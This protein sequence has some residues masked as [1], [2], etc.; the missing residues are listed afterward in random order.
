MPE[1][2]EEMLRRTLGRT[3]VQFR[4]AP[5]LAEIVLSSHQRV[6]AEIARVIAFE[7][8]EPTFL[9]GVQSL[10]FGPKQLFRYD[11]PAHF[12]GAVDFFI[13]KQTWSFKNLKIDPNSADS[14]DKYAAVAKAMSAALGNDY[15]VIVERTDNFP[16]A[17]KRWEM[18]FLNGHLNRNWFLN[19]RRGSNGDHIHIQPQ[20]NDERIKD[21]I[22]AEFDLT[23]AVSELEHAQSEARE[24]RLAVTLVNERYN[25]AKTELENARRVENEAAIDAKEAAR[26]IRIE[27]EEKEQQ[28]REEARKAEERHSEAARQQDDAQE[29]A[30]SKKRSRDAK[31]LV[32]PPLAREVQDPD[33]QNISFMELIMLILKAIAESTP[34]ILSKQEAEEAYQ[35]AVK[36]LQELIDSVRSA[37]DVEDYQARWVQ[38]DPEYTRQ[39]IEDFL[40][41]LNKPATPDLK[42]DLP[43]CGNGFIHNV[44]LMLG[45]L[46]E[47]DI[48]A[49]IVSSTF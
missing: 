26:R 15:L 47:K 8:E 35:R 37:S 7:F 41:Y 44:H 32:T 2:N 18:Q 42:T 38:E 29:K 40:K 39:Q 22:T 9:F 16:P 5:E 24:A 45:L 36:R 23:I 25:E 6:S 30:D 14:N 1:T 46:T 31:R 13:N 21:Y 49:A 12:R 33:N 20:L 27:K 19:D 3:A 48:H 11:S 17:G 10:F 28:T 4:P 34:E 43:W